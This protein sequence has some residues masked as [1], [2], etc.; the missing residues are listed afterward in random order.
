MNG[1]AAFPATGEPACCQKRVEAAVPRPKGRQ[2]DDA[3]QLRRVAHAGLV[4]QN[5]EEV[6]DSPL[7]KRPGAEAGVHLK[8]LEEG[9]VEARPQNSAPDEGWCRITHGRPQCCRRELQNETE[10]NHYAETR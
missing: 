5:Q 2:A 8:T 1:P 9:V 3:E 4:A 7:G 6:A 10:A